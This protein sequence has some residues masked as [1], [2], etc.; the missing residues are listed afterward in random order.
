MFLIKSLCPGASM[1]VTKYLLVSNFHR[2]IS[3]VIPHSRSAFSLS[4]T[5]AYLKELFP[6][7]AASFSNFLIVL[8]SIPP[9]L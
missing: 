2:E 5:Q 7:S 4:K 1:M 8:L 9:H 6:I 3:M